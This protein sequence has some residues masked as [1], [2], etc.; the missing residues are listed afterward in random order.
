[1][2]EVWAAK[3]SEIK[4]LVSSMDALKKQVALAKGNLA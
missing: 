1:M 3:N 2:V 4:A